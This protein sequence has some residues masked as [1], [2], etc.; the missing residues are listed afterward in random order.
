M[1]KKINSRQKGKRG[2]LE[3]CKVCK[4]E[5]FEA[6]RGAQHAGKNLTTSE[7]SPDV[8]TPDLNIHY[9]VKR[10]ERLNLDDA[11]A[12][13][14]RDANPGE[15]AAVSHRKNNG[16]WMVTMSAEDHFNLVRN[17]DYVKTRTTK[18]SGTTRKTF[19]YET[20]GV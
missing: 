10:V 18:E 15:I 13:A 5:G 8:I 1:P 16:P 9:E 19:S 17:S 14:Q 4:A 2:E 12:Q 6:F 11:L 7:A 20:S 3:W